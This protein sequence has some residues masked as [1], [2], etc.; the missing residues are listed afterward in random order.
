M[1]DSSET[2]SS[3]TLHVER[4][5][6]SRRGLLT[7]ATTLASGAA[8]LVLLPDTT[9][10]AK[11]PAEPSRS[12]GIIVASDSNGLAETTAGKVR[13]YV[14]HGIYT[15]KGIPYAQ[16]TAGKGRFMP[17]MKPEPWTGVR[18]SLYYGQVCPQAP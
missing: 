5:P 1:R 16:S 17:P 7:A 9:E 10:A 14:R 3:E 18:S 2:N 11:R 12:S 15:Y 6:I 8:G 13:G 4:S